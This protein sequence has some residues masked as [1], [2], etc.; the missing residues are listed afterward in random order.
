MKATLALNGLRQRKDYKV[1]LKN[2]QS[3][4]GWWITKYNR[5]RLQ[6]ETGFDI[7]RAIKKI[8]KCAR[9]CKVLQGGLQSTIAIK[10]CNWIKKCDS[11]RSGSSTLLWI[12]FI[13]GMFLRKILKKSIFQDISSLLLL[14]CIC[15]LWRLG[16]IS[17]LKSFHSLS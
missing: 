8:A 16:K 11:T 15:K 9:D 6:D 4:T 17:R 2:L 13:S 10:K 7:Q 12:T 14:H 1:L 3:A 5:S